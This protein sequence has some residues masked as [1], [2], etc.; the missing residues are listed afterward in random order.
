MNTEPTTRKYWP[1][2]RKGSVS[3]PP[4]TVNSPAWT[5]SGTKNQ[6]FKFC[7]TVSS[8]TLSSFYSDLVTVTVY[9]F[10]AVPFFTFT[11]KVLAPVAQVAA[12]PFSTGVSPLR[13]VTVALASSGVAV[14]VLVAFVVVAVYSVAE[15]NAGVSVSAPIVSPERRALKGPG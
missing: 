15:S 5:P 4:C 13:M 11:V 7:K 8:I 14:T 12:V 3:C 6:L 10:S 1:V 9:T 2:C